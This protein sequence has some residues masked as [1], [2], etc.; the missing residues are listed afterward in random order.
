MDSRVKGD[1]EYAIIGYVLLHNP[2]WEYGADIQAQRVNECGWRVNKRDE[3]AFSV[4]RHGEE[5]STSVSGR[6][7]E[8]ELRALKLQEN[9][10][11]RR[12]R[13]IV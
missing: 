1:G 12:P 10:V 9:G 11:M 13:D 3:V 8:H 4:E 5:M 2:A 6:T 7:N